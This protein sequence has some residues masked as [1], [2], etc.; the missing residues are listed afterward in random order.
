LFH[1]LR[2]ELVLAERIHLLG[3]DDQR[4]DG[5][6]EDAV[7]A[8]VDDVFSAV[9]GSVRAAFS[10]FPIDEGAGATHLDDFGDD[11]LCVTI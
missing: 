5:A 2:R 11:L 6:A 1:E 3:K 10:R 4:R 8:P 9:R 7:D